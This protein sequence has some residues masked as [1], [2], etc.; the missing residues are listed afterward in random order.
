MTSRKGL[1]GKQRKEESKMQGTGQRRREKVG[2]Q[3]EKKKS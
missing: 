1:G 2:T 3:K